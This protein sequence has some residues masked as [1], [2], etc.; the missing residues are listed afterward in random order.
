M[1]EEITTLNYKIYIC[2]KKGMPRHSW[3]SL[4]VP[5]P[6]HVNTGPEGVNI[7]FYFDNLWLQYDKLKSFKIFSSTARWYKWCSYTYRFKLEG[8]TSLR[9]ICL[10]WPQLFSQYRV[11]NVP[12]NR[13][14]LTWEILHCKHLTQARE[15]Q[16][17]SL[18][19]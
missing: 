7:F 14:Q 5:A 12:W 10:H 18:K 11:G 1:V 15:I 17:F 3:K 13:K 9:D 16:A 4:L 8:I 19:I 2:L 6:W